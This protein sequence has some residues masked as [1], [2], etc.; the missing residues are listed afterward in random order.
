MSRVDDAREPAL[1]ARSLR[2]RSHPDHE[3]SLD[4]HAGEVVGLAGL[5]GAGRSELLRALFLADEPLSGT[6]T[7]GGR[8]LRVRRGSP[9]QA[10]GAGLAYVPEDRKTEGLFLEDSVARNLSLAR[11][12][13]DAR[14]GF[15]DRSKERQLVA[16]AMR[17]TGIKAA[18]DAEPVSQLSGGNQQK[19]V[20][21]RAFA[22]APR[23]L[24]LDEPTR[25]VDVGAKSEI[26]R[27][28]EEHAERGGGVLFASSEMEEILGLC[29]RCLVMHEGRIA[30]ELGRSELTEEA[31]M[32][33][34]TGGSAT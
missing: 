8:S 32:H 21:G 11:L 22:T 28:I 4:V 27:L 1:S 13:E 9:A 24:L 34:A 7:V 16:D 26:Y 15:V 29:D 12:R 2:T 23:V 31:V 19:V 30:G 14:L 17:E 6:V 3:S 5:V 18:S 20:L 10:L 25:G 33:L